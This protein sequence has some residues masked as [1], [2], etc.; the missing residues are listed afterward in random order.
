MIQHVSGEA[1]QYYS[2]A[3]AI[4]A[5]SVEVGS[6]N[7]RRWFRYP[8]CY[9]TAWRMKIHLVAC[10]H[11]PN[12]VLVT[13]QAVVSCEVHVVVAHVRCDDVGRNGAGL[14]K[15][16][17]VQSCCLEASTPA[18]DDVPSPSRLLPSNLRTANACDS[19]CNFEFCC[20]TFPTSKLT[21]LLF[22]ILRR[23]ES[24]IRAMPSDQH[25]PYDLICNSH[26]AF[27]SLQCI[28][29]GARHAS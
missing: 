9:Y 5:W 15:H 6:V 24:C 19:I 18:S 1:F 14:R 21:R 8:A 13:V 16:G 12:S 28:H 2:D 25:D 17:S 23:V 26:E 11:E 4:W 29:D 10:S 22:S 20:S 3:E 7:A 27:T